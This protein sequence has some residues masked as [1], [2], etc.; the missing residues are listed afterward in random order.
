MVVRFHFGFDF[1]DPAM[2]EP[3]VVGDFVPDGIPYFGL[4]LV[5]VAAPLLDR[6]FENGDFIRQDQ[7]VA[8]PAR[9]KWNTFV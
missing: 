8:C 2:A 4:Q 6:P 1:A 5:H 9:R 7:V 3:E